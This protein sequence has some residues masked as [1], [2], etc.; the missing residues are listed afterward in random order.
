MARNQHAEKVKTIRY[1]NIQKLWLSSEEMSYDNYLSLHN[2]RI[3]NFLK[4]MEDKWLNNLL[5]MKS[6][7]TAQIPPPD[8]EI[9][10]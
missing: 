9:A 7:N 10:D 1:E 5:N 6:G 8:S 4:N 3:N 2:Q